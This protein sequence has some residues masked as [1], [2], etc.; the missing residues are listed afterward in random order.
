MTQSVV[1][2]IAAVL[3]LTTAAIK[4]SLLKFHSPIVLD[5]QMYYAP[6]CRFT[7]LLLTELRHSLSKS[8]SEWLA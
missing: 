8:Q 2:Q 1:I 5:F 3:G 7:E 6:V 4:T